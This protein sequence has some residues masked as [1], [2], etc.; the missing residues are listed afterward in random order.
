MALGPGAEAAL[1]FFTASF[2]SPSVGSVAFCCFSG[3]FAGSIRSQSPSTSSRLG[4]EWV[5]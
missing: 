3:S 5:T 1:A 4:S 2:A